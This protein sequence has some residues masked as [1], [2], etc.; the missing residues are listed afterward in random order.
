[1]RAEFRIMRHVVRLDSFDTVAYLHAQNEEEL[2]AEL[3]K[4]RPSLERNEMLVA[5][6]GP[7]LEMLLRASLLETR[8]AA[9]SERKP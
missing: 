8:P 9:E 6:N 3:E 7:A 2:L 5:V 4:W 1:M